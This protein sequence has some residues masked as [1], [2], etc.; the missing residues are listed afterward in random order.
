LWLLLYM[1]L[2]G[3]FIAA[4]PDGRAMQCALVLYAALLL[5]LLLLLQRLRW[6]LLL[7][8]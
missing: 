3:W 5:L 6:L 8:M 1:L 4:A 7:L 2:A